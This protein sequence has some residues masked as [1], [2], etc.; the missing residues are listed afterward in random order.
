MD[1]LQGYSSESD[2]ETRE[3]E[4]ESQLEL[5]SE[6]PPVPET[7]IDRYSIPPNT[8][9]F[10]ENI[11][12]MRF[13]SPFKIKDFQ[14]SKGKWS[15]FLFLEY[16]PSLAERNN[17]LYNI[18][19]FNEENLANVPG[20]QKFEPLHISSLGVAAPLHISLSRNILFDDATERDQFYHSLSKRVA[21][22]SQFLVQFEDRLKILTAREKSTLYLTLDLAQSVKE[23]CISPIMAAIEE[24]LV[25]TRLKTPRSYLFDSQY[26]HMS[27]ATI[28]NAKG[29]TIDEYQPQ[30]SS[31]S[32]VTPYIYSNTPVF[33][34]SAIK[35][36]RNRQILTIP[37]QK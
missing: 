4:S 21:P 18:T 27:I 25:E 13:T 32:R 10:T 7:I 19:K 35:Y 30:D 2:L 29:P 34:A 3:S 12:S 26:A 15:S 31:T 28:K 37:L 9:N 11:E 16:N 1:L 36:N 6:L 5:E 22:M 8:L 24:S 23:Q 33:Y 14:A 20:L 17:L